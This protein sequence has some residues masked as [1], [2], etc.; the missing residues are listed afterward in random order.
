MSARMALPAAALTLVIAAC[1]GSD[2]NKPSVKTPTASQAAANIAAARK[3]CASVPGLGG[4]PKDDLPPDVRLLDG[5]K[6]YKSQ[7]PFGRTEIFYASAAGDPGSLPSVRDDAA[8]ALTGY[9]LLATDQEKDSEAEAHL[10]GSGHTVDLQV[11]PLCKGKVR[12]RYTV[13]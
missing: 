10:K 1:G 7:G 5:A 6:L 3:D 13:E 11:I 4:K 9:Q 2:N 8:K 12:I